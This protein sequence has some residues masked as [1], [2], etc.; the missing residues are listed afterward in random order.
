[1]PVNE[2]KIKK[3][4]ISIIILNIMFIFLTN[5]LSYN[6]GRFTV[7]KEVHVRDYEISSVNQNQIGVQNIKK[8][9][10]LKCESTNNF[11]WEKYGIKDG[12]Y[13]LG[14]IKNTDNLS[15]ESRILLN[16]KRR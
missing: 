6:Y 5:I 8:E 4:V 16:I 3:E 15:T 14:P 7:F 13:S 10:I 12:Y 11:N 9:I 1:M 2:S